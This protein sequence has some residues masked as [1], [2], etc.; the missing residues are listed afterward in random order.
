VSAKDN[1]L[2][3][4]RAANTAQAATGEV[5]STA[6]ARLSAHPRG[7]MPTMTWDP[8]VQF[9]ACSIAAASTIDEVR[10]RVELP[11]AVARYLRQNSL[12]MSGVCW[13]EFGDLDWLDAGLEMQSRPATGDDKVGVTGSFCALAETGTLVLLSGENQAATTSLLPE[14]H[15]AVVN[16][17]RVVV[18]MEDVWD[19]LR[20]ETGGLPRQINFVSG[21]SRT[22]DIEMTLVYGAHGPFRVHVLLLDE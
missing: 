15:I 9:R 17:G 18:S 8:L 14:T 7:P 1:I 4:I 6:A 2:A 5:A 16:T 10:R 20:A 21:P 13:P 11:A 22:A 19:L 3:R 12:P